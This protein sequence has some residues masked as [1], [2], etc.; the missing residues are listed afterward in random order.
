MCVLDI[1][2]EVRSLFELFSFPPNLFPFKPSPLPP[3]PP[4]SIYPPPL[5]HHSIQGVKQVLA[6]DLNARILFLYPPSI[7]ELEARLR[8]RGTETEES[9]ARRLKQAE[10]EMAFAREAGEKMVV[11]DDLERAYREVEEWVVD[12]GKF[13]D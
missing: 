4:P 10:V 8:G 2:M 7:R 1:E 3:S 9:V 5:T 11:N 12:G 6:T 13:G